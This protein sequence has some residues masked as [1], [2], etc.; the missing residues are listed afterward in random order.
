MMLIFQFPGRHFRNQEFREY[1]EKDLL[2]DIRLHKYKQVSRIHK[3]FT[4]FNSQVLWS[5]ICV[6]GFKI[7]FD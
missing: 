6:I 7:I 3:Q 5:F 1:P 4:G 2:V